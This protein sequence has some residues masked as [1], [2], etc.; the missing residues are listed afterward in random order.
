M[1]VGAKQG[2]N[3]SDSGE[4]L[5]FDLPKIKAKGLMMR[6]ELD[7]AAD[8]GPT[9]P[10]VLITSPSPTESLTCVRENFLLRRF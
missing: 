4:T 7:P 5:T 9:L 3:W 6:A 10:G 1:K 2:N 8:G